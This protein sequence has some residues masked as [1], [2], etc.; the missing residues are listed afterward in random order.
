MRSGDK[1][2]IYCVLFY[3]SVKKQKT[4]EF[5]EKNTRALYQKLINE[6]SL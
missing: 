4:I 5:A 1:I 6:S 3:V 2:H